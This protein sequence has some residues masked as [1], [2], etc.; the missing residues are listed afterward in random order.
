MGVPVCEQLARIKERIS[1]GTFSFT[2]E[3]PNFRNLEYVP[4][5]GFTPY[6]RP[7]E[8]RRVELCPRALLHRM[9]VGAKRCSGCGQSA[10]ANPTAPDT[11][12]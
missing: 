7:G 8:A 11:R 5:G 10:T 6:V 2:E 3:F 9:S 12:P 4:H 1:A